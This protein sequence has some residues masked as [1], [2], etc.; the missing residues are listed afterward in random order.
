MLQLFKCMDFAQ[1]S[2][3]RDPLAA[4]TQFS[5]QF[6]VPSG[7]HEPGP[8]APSSQIRN[9]DYAFEGLDEGQFVTKAGKIW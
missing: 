1:T 9:I 8:H 6:L 2:W 4:S 3:A 7:H 5:Q